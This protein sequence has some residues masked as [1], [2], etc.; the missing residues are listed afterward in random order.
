M[1]IWV[2]KLPREGYNQIDFW[3]KINILQVNIAYCEETW[4]R[5]IKNWTSFQ[6]IKSCPENVKNKNLT[7]KLLLYKENLFQRDSYH[8]IDFVS[9]IFALF[10]NSAQRSLTKYNN[11]LL[12]C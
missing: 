3:P 10:D 11:F 4:Y 8:K 2:V 12:V 1:A 9:Q 7:P 5:V 6:R